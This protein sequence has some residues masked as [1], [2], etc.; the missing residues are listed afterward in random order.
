[1]PIRK[2]GHA[3]S[4]NFRRHGRSTRHVVRFLV[5]F[6]LDWI[7]PITTT[8][9]PL[10][11]LWRN[12]GKATSVN[13]KKAIT[14]TECDW[15]RRKRVPI[16]HGKGVSSRSGN[17]IMTRK[18]ARRLPTVFLPCKRAYGNKS[19]PDFEAGC[20]KSTAA[21]IVDEL[22]AL[23]RLASACGAGMIG[24]ADYVRVTIND[25]PIR[26][27][28]HRWQVMGECVYCRQAQS[29]PFQRTPHELPFFAFP[30]IGYAHHKES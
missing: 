24:T 20:S 9:K 27:Q 12:T 2:K 17:E 7:T 19:S 28:L 11:C 15:P 4:T 5:Q 3:C 18:L 6:E 13:R 23:R 16:V 29:K 22:F 26:H 8:K 14:D 30:L 21:R 25:S 1:V 10:I